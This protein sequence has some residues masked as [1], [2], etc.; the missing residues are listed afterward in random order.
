MA[1]GIGASLKNRSERAAEAVAP[2]VKI[3]GP[4]S[5]GF[6]GFVNISV[7]EIAKNLTDAA[8]AD[9]ETLKGRLDQLIKETNKRLVIVVDDIDRM[10]HGEIHAVFQLIKACGDF[11]RTNLCLGF[12]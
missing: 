1:S 9:V 12:R 3:L 5:G 10:D 8:T 11:L 7:A 2:Y 6:P 4:I